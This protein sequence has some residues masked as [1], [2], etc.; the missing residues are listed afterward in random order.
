MGAYRYKLDTDDGKTHHAYEHSD[1]TWS[2]ESQF[3]ARGF[4]EKEASHCASLEA[5]IV[6][7]Q[8]K[9]GAEVIRLREC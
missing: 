2:I 8:A 7:L 9:T 5:A 3:L 6:L 1:G 4:G